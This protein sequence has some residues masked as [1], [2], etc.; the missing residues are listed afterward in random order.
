VLK[1]LDVKNEESIREKARQKKERDE[2]LQKELDEFMAAN[3][4]KKASKKKY[5]SSEKLNY[6][7]EPKSPP[8]SPTKLLKKSSG[9]QINGSKK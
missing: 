6:L 5:A 9:F 1:E 4:K 3:S 8:K 7:S 2:K